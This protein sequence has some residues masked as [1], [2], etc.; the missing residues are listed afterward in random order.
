MQS[1]PEDDAVTAAD[2]AAS[3]T[4]AAAAAAAK[5]A[6]AAAAAAT[7]YAARRQAHIVAT[8]TLVQ[9]LERVRVLEVA[10]GGRHALARGGALH[11]CSVAAQVAHWHSAG[12]RL[13]PADDGSVWT[14][15]HG[16]H[17]KLGRGAET[18]DD[19]IHPEPG[20]VAKLWQASFHCVQVCAGEDHSLA[21]GGAL[22]RCAAA[23]RDPPSQPAVLGGAE[24]V[25][26][27]GQTQR[28]VCAWGSNAL[29][30][31]GLGKRELRDHAT[32]SEVWALAEKRVHRIACGARHC[33]AVT[34]ATLRLARCRSAPMLS[35]AACSA[36]PFVGTGTSDMGTRVYAWG[37]NTWGQLGAWWWSLLLSLPSSHDANLSVQ[38][39]PRIRTPGRSP[40]W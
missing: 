10:T 13:P 7:E 1:L 14:W 24:V 8:P 23:R 33:L 16:G 26:H 28:Q 11:A 3:A 25:D 12:R 15:G 39:W 36:E 18:A 6:Q 34:G 35:T 37:D 5:R 32:P 9:G 27:W 17:G 20:R 22:H 19:A 30:Q 4:A 31:L 21:L 29:G 2:S 40:R 38:A